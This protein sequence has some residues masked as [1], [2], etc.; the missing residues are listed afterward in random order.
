MISFSCPQ[1]ARELRVR[2]ELAGKK[3]RCPH[4]GTIAPIAIPSQ[5]VPK[6][7]APSLATASGGK[8]AA[9]KVRAG[10]P[11]PR[12]AVFQGSEQETQPPGSPAETG[13]SPPAGPLAA[14]VPG[15]EI[16]GELG[17]GGMGVV[18]KARHLHSIAWSH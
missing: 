10:K 14:Q 15:Y 4:C 13:P 17:R 11:A 7:A 2:D 12:E 8:P 3:V 5:G 6:T 16:L 1:C 18:Y 9:G